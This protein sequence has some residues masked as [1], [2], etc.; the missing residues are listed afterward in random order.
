MVE[1]DKDRKATERGLV[2]ASQ[3]GRYDITYNEYLATL[4]LRGDSKDS[5]AMRLALASSTDPRFRKF[6]ELV[7]NGQFRRASLAA[8]AKLCEIGL[9]EFQDWRQ[10]AQTQR[11]LAKAQDGVL[12]MTDDLVDEARARDA[13]CDRCDGLGSVICDSRAAKAP[14]FRKIKGMRAEDDSYMRD[15]PQCKGKGIV[16]APGSEHA[17]DKLLDMTGMSGRSKGGV[18]VNI[19]QTFGGMG[20]ESAV[21][22]LNKVTFDLEDYEVVPDPAPANPSNLEE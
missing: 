6:L 1:R 5:Q 19:N 16:R 11:I 17:R 21:D 8:I 2:P 20:M 14:G 9:T 22:R 12:S 4:D 18:A 15:C 10:K 3:F 13:S 7:G